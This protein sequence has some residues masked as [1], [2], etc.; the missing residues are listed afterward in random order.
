LFPSSVAV[1]QL[2][3]RRHQVYISHCYWH[4]LLL[5]VLFL[6]IANLILLGI[7]EYLLSR[8]PPPPTIKMEENTDG[9]IFLYWQQCTQCCQSVPKQNS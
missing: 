5:I 9:I 4:R 1:T 6:H 3:M 8:E 2:F 7:R